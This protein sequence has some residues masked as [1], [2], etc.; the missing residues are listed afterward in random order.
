MYF[1]DEWKGLVD[2]VS[3]KELMSGADITPM[4][5]RNKKET[6]KYCIHLAEVAAYAVSAYE[7][8]NVSIAKFNNIIPY[9]VIRCSYMSADEYGEET[10]VV[11]DIVVFD[12]AAEIYSKIISEI[13]KHFEDNE[14]YSDLHIKSKSIELFFKYC[15][16]ESGEFIGVSSETIRDIILTYLATREMPAIRKIEDRVSL[17]EIVAQNY[18]DGMSDKEVESV[19][20]NVWDN[21]AKVR[22][23]YEREFYYGM[24]RVYFNRKKTVKLSGPEFVLPPKEKWICGK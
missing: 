17:T 16:Q 6:L 1:V 7:S 9:G 3:P 18:F 13:E 12:E 20:K 24:M 19:I 11:R 2:F 8:H 21:N 10:E 4:H 5:S 23:W 15:E 14:E 22:S